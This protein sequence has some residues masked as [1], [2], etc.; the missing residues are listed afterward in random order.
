MGMHPTDPVLLQLLEN[1]ARQAQELS[2]EETLSLDA[3][4]RFSYLVSRASTDEALRCLLEKTLAMLAGDEEIKKKNLHIT[5]I[6]N[7][8][9]MQDRKRFTEMVMER[10]AS[11]L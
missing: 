3:M 4:Q 5:G 1:A 2:S 7:H 9:T 11:S 8:L 6:I 10:L